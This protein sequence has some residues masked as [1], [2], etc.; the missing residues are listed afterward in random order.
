M[1]KS[2]NNILFKNNSA[3]NNLV[4]YFLL[5]YIIRNVKNRL[6]YPVGISSAV[7]VRSI[8]EVRILC[9][10]IVVYIATNYRFKREFTFQMGNKKQEEPMRLT[11][12]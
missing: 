10:F 12:N 2:Q 4:S 6:S 1:Q 11:E 8:L 5:L 3:S 9:D 7:V